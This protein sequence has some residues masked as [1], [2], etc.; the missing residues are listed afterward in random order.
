MGA[1]RE[2]KALK[3]T[4]DSITPHGSV[5]NQL[6]DDFYEAMGRFIAYRQR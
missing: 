2:G 5:E 4:P 3:R 1:G 6:Q